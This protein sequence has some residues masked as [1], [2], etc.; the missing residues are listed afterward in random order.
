MGAVNSTIK[1]KI[2]DLFSSLRG[3]KKASIVILGL[4]NAG[5]STLVNLLQGVTT[6]PIPTI[7]FNIEEIVFNNTTITICDIGG[8]STFR[9]F[10]NK[11]VSTMDGLVFMIDICDKE[12]FETSYH[13]FQK[14]FNELKNGISV[15]LLLNK[16]DKL[17]N[18]NEIKEARERIEKL[19]KVS[20]ERSTANP[21]IIADDNGLNKEFKT[22]IYTLSVMDDIEKVKNDSSFSISQSSVYQG[23]SWLIDNIN[24]DK[25]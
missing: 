17:E 10:W 20:T 8:Q 24:K 18:A 2:S 9:N 25:K 22:K 14:M 5:K 7:G 16:I 23:F 15:L 1:T 11:Y 3:R 6:P 13:A 4:D 12:R 19:Y 21:V